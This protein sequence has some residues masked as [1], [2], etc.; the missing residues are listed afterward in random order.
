MNW[1]NWTALGLLHC[2]VYLPQCTPFAMKMVAPPKA[3]ASPPPSAVVWPTNAKGALHCISLLWMSLLVLQCITLFFFALHCFSLLQCVFQYIA[4]KALS[5]NTLQSMKNQEELQHHQC[6]DDY[7]IV[8]LRPS[9]HYHRPQSS[10]TRSDKTCWKERL[11][12]NYELCDAGLPAHHLCTALILTHSTAHVGSDSSLCYH[13]VYSVHC[14]VGHNVPCNC[15]QILKCL[16][17]DCAF[18]LWRGWERDRPWPVSL[19]YMTC[20]CLNPPTVHP[21]RVL[22]N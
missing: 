4:C 19:R 6:E 8:H 14:T 7:Y 9:L 20:T 18:T 15:S 2:T 11:G 16:T 1:P 10:D 3:L 5:C 21:S 13:H 17:F 12:L 22:D